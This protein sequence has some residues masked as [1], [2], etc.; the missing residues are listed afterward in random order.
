MQFEFATASRIIFGN[1]KIS[2]IGKI[3][4][5]EGSKAL[6]VYGSSLDR[7]SHL[8][9]SLADRGIKYCSYSVS[10]EP[11]IDVV[12]KGIELCRTEGCDLVIGV[13]GGSVIDTGKAIALLSANEG[14]VSDYLEVIGQGKDISTPGISMIAI[15]TTAGTGSE[16]T[17]NAVIGVEDHKIK[18]SLRSQYMLPGVALIDP[19]L[20][21]SMPPKVTASTGMDAMTQLIEP[22]VS[23][24]ANPI[25]D[26]FCQEGLEYAAASIR[27]VYHDGSDIE[28]RVKMSLASLFSGF[29]LAN[30]KLGAVHGFTGVLGGMFAAPHGEICASLLPAVLKVNIRALQNRNLNSDYLSRYERIAQILTGRDDCNAEDAVEFIEQLKSDLQIPPLS[31]FGVLE[32]DYPEIIV[33]AASSSSMKGNPVSLTPDEMYTILELSQ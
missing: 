20:S 13:G 25:T 33:K 31:Q 28:A 17:R 22:Y 32:V 2:E 16:V 10:T 29:A 23:N 14:D 30:A 27:E 8:I 3:A 1:G 12:R 18:V 19:E 21:T 5:R 24:Q 4:R 6:V 9:L 15:P 26:V 7:Y 11:T